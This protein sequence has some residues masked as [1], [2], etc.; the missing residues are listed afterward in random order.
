MAEKDWVC[1]NCGYIYKPEFGDPDG[2]VPPGTRWEDL[3]E[4]W[5]CPDCTSGKDGFEYLEH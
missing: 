4:D 2:G 5:R 1:L 3:P